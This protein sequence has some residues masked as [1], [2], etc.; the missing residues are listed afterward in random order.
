M[1][2]M[3]IDVNAYTDV[4]A[5]SPHVSVSHFFLPD[6]RAITICP[7]SCLFVGSGHPHPHSLTSLNAAT[8][9][10]SRA[11]DTLRHRPSR[12]RGVSGVRVYAHGQS[13]QILLRGNNLISFEEQ[14][15][16]SFVRSLTRS[17]TNDEESTMGGHHDCGRHHGM[18][19]I[20]CCGTAKHVTHRRPD[21]WDGQWGRMP[22]PP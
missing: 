4:Y 12:Q 6:I 9:S 22:F 21:G 18:L 16:F 10:D 8:A 11:N 3:K 5:A 17:L 2:E 7:V 1:R 20:L 13:G 15:H 19:C 14:D